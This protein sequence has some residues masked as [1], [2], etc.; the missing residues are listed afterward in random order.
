MGIK[1]VVSEAQSGLPIEAAAIKVRNVTSGR[2][3]DVD[4]DITTIESGEYWR[5]LT[6]GQYEVTA[7]K[8]GYEAVT[9]LVTVANTHHQEAFRVDFSLQPSTEF[10]PQAFYP[11]NNF[12]GAQANGGAEL[13]NPDLLKLFSYLRRGEQ[14]MP[15]VGVPQEPTR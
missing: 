2:N 11:Y 13:S 1:G 15:D 10:D 6:P 5:L 14:N 12:E 4:H 7:M 3:Q 9:K 8:T